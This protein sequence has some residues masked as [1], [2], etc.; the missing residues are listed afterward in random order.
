MKPV[1]A[2]KQNSQNQN[3]KTQDQGSGGCVG[4]RVLPG[5][6]LKHRCSGAETMML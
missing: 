3:E 2:I 1:W 5:V 4:K 6:C